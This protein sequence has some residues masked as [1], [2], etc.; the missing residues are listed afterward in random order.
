MKRMERREFL[1]RSSALAVGASLIGTGRSWAGA[2]DRIRVAIIGMGVRG[3]QHAQSVARFKDVEIAAICDPDEKRLA[4]WAGKVESLTQKKPKTES[5]LRKIMDDPDIDAVMIANCNHWHALTAIYACQAKKHAYVEKPVMH[6][7]SEGRKMVEAARKYD[8]IVCGGTQRR[9][10]GRV[11]KLIQLLHDGIIGDLYMGRWVITGAR[12][13][14]GFKQPTEPPSWLH[15]DLWRGP[16]R[17]QPYHENLVHYNWHWFWDF[18]NGEMGNNGPHS[19]DVVRWALRKG[20]PSRIH[21]VGG[22]FGYKDQAE[23]PNTQTATFRYDDGT[24]LTCDIRGW[25]NNEPDGSWFYGSKGSAF[26]GAG[27]DF[28][29][30]LGRNK[31]PLPPP[32][33]KSFERLDH[34]RV[35]FDAIRKGD[36]K[37]LTAEIEETFLSCALCEL[38]N[39]SYRVGREVRFD[40]QTERFIGDAEADKLR[41]REPHPPFVVPETV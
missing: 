14:I 17:S 23:T 20:L 28:K 41:M 40:P 5:D 12:G 39:I 22:R 7:L 29:I 9:S 27:E 38:A 36:R 31:E 6:N 33:P 16:A 24:L 34:A 15:W 11:R 32:D 25:H 8:R 30:F 18:G 2:N 21:S 26:I 37:V 13:S 1:K 10:D 35:F 3:G 19:I 4:E